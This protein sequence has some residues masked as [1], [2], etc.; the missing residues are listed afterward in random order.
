MTSTTDLVTPIVHLNGTSRDSLLGQR[1]DAYDA[2]EKAAAALRQ[3]APNGRD[4]YLEEGRLQKAEAQHMRRLA[5][6]R[7]LQDEIEREMHL[8]CDD[9]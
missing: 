6:I 7:S 1:S 9:E 4:Y 3:M 5:A 2:L 8:I